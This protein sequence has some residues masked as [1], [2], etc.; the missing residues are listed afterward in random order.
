MAR[1]LNR[2]CRA[3]REP[4]RA[5]P[6]LVVSWA[7]TFRR[8]DHPVCAAS[9]A[10]RYFCYGAAT[11]PLRGG[12][13]APVIKR[14]EATEAAQTG[15]S[16]R[17]ALVFAELTTP[18]APYRNGNFFLMVRPPLLCEEGNIAQSQMPRWSEATAKA[19]LL[20]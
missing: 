4:D 14:S 9:V 7:E 1:Q 15:W 10:S 20:F 19:L 16:E 13:A 8:S 5:K 11:P 3:E 2:S 17:R 6:Q 18:A 12:V